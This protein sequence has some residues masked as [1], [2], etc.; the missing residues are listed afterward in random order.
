MKPRYIIPNLGNSAATTNNQHQGPVVIIGKNGSGKTRLG[1]WIEEK[2]N[3]PQ[4]V[5][6]ISAQRALQIPPQITFQSIADAEKDLIFGTTHQPENYFTKLKYLYQSKPHNFILNDFHKV[7]SILFAKKSVRDSEVVEKIQAGT[8]NTATDTI[9]LCVTDQIEVIWNEIYPHRNILFKDAKVQAC[10]PHTTNFYEGT[11]MSDG[12]R[13]ALYLMSQVLCVPPNTIL[14]LDEPE[15]H[16]N[17]TIINQLWDKLEAYRAD[18][19]FVYITHNLEFAKSRTNPKTYFIESYD[20][21]NWNYSNLT[22]L[23]NLPADLL[24]DLVGPRRKILFIEGELGSLDYQIYSEYY[25]ELKV[26]PVASCENVI[27]YTQSLNANSALHSFEAFGLIDRDYRSQEHLDKLQ[28]Q[29]IYTIGVAESENL[30]I[31]ENVIKVVAEYL[32][33]PDYLTKVESIKDKVIARLKG[34]I[35]NGK[36]PTNFT[37]QAIKY[38]LGS[39]EINHR[40]KNALNAHYESI[41]ATVDIDQIYEEYRLKLQTIVDER[42]YDEAIKY[43]NRKSLISIIATELNQTSDGY[44]Q[45]IVTSIQEDCV[46]CQRDNIIAAIDGCLPEIE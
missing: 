42:D 27:K 24:M 8:Y 35:D 43:Y 11:D 33:I 29:K 36:Q 21:T 41:K 46:D 38:K 16:L 10:I 7:L 14:I 6:R 3:P 9:D 19:L 5:K 17:R 28:T 30:M 18:C 34:E 26:I 22:G 45:H 1:I 39:F 12:E 37:G 4:Q 15:I 31:T 44:I 32:K 40:D 25:G 2:T 20:G 13:V 23:E